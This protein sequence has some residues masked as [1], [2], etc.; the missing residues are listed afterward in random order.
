MRIVITDHEVSTSA[1]NR[2]ELDARSVVLFTSGGESYVISQNAEGALRIEAPSGELSM[3]IISTTPKI[4]HVTAQG[5]S[6]AEGPRIV[7]NPKPRKVLCE[8][9]DS[10]IEYDLEDLFRP[11]SLPS[12]DEVSPLAVKC[13][14]PRCGGRGYPR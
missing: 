7:K 4:A 9:C 5:S 6:R 14:K 8:R 11:L 10:T 13:P 12:S 3:D 2:I 1:P